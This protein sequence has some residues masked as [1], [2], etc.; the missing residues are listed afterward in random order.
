MAQQKGIL[1]IEGTMGSMTF[2][3]KDGQYL[4]KEKA[5]FQRIKLPIIP[6]LSV[7]GKITLNLVW[8]VRP[9]NS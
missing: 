4:V 8:P 9:A 1:K 7:L 2:Y 6:T 5:L 3:K